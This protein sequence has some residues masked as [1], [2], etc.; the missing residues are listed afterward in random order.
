MANRDYRILRNFFFVDADS[1]QSVTNEVIEILVHQP[2]EA[3]HLLAG[4]SSRENEKKN[5][6]D[7]KTSINVLVLEWLILYLAYLNLTLT[8][9][10]CIKVGE[11]PVST[12]NICLTVEIVVG[13]WWTLFAHVICNFFYTVSEVIKNVLCEL[14][15]AWELFMSF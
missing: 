14:R 10:V 5:A 11:S 8:R 13:N 1:K 4:E 15:Y 2:R 6:R 7:E 12:I 3:Q 9:S